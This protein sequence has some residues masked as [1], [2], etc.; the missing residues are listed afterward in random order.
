M[1]LPAAAAALATGA[2]TAGAL[3]AGALTAGALTA[4]A[5]TT[6]AA[7][8]VTPALA[9]GHPIMAPMTAAHA[10]TRNS[11]PAH[12]QLTPA[13]PAKARSTTARATT[14]RA[15][16]KKHAKTDPLKIVSLYGGGKYMSVVTCKGTKVPP[17]LHLKAS[18]S[19]LTLR[20]LVPSAAQLESV[21]KNRT[22]TTVYTCTVVVEEDSP[23]PAKATPKPKP[24]P[25]CELPVS[26]SSPANACHRKVALNTGFGGE[27]ASVAHHHPHG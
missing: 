8:T 3:T 15:A 25:T 22:Y 27:A 20:G 14:A 6:A 26:G 5:L 17:P 13:K 9:A 12:G 10:T 11:A 23:A 7:T 1:R 21:T 4:V 19:P 18:G 16:G 2:L 24:K